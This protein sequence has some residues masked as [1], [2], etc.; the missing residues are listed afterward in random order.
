MSTMV[1]NKTKYDAYHSGA[2]T[3][4][5]S[6]YNIT[7]LLDGD[8]EY[9][10]YISGDYWVVG[11]VEI[12]AITPQ[13]I[14]DSA[15]DNRIINGAMVNP[16][17][18]V[19][20]QGYDSESQY[21]AFDNTTNVAYMV[22]EGSPLTLSAGD[23]LV[24]TVSTPAY[25][26]HSHTQIEDGAI[27]TVVSVAPSANA[28]RPPYSGTDKATLT[29]TT[30]DVDFDLVENTGMNI[31]GIQNLLTWEEAELAVQRPR[32]AEH[33]PQF[34]RRSVAPYSNYTAYGRD[35]TR[36]IT[37]SVM[38]VMFDDYTPEEKRNTIIYL[39]Q[40]GIDMWGIHREWIDNA[41]TNPWQVPGS[42]AGRK[43]TIMLAMKFLQ[44]TTA[45]AE[46]ATIPY[47]ETQAYYEDAQTYWVTQT[48]VD[49]SNSVD[50][51]PDYRSSGFQAYTTEMIGMPEW[52]GGHLDNPNTSQAHWGDTY[53]GVYYTMWIEAFIANLLGFR[54]EWN[55]EPFFEYAHRYV[56]LNRGFVD[57]FGYTM[58]EGTE[59]TLTYGSGLGDDVI[60]LYW[61]TLY[62]V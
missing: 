31:A 61:D 7:W 12:I 34:T 24:S 36:E 30:D 35:F 46:F 33:I 11:P 45:L 27:L 1:L 13:S 9:G 47:T 53:R 32:T 3:T 18:S 39:I 6:Q 37:D 2:L 28:F 38:M 60:D 62:S 58:V 49:I 14:T 50:W 17:G 25:D 10:Q 23:S 15:D 56:M 42:G 41:R 54:T 4:E 29:F 55:H 43:F 22:D 51:D 20:V 8:V 16:E 57:P 19:S 59:N 52:S 40:I 21:D 48:E 5:L 26:T 44:Q